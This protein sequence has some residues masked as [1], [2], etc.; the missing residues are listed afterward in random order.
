MTKFERLAAVLNEAKKIMETEGMANFVLID[1]DQT[2]KI[3][4]LLKDGETEADKFLTETKR[5]TC[6]INGKT[7]NYVDRIG[8]IGGVKF[9]ATA[10]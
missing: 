2:D 1:L 9:V 10:G 4:V 3:K 5:G 7:K 8:E 6:C